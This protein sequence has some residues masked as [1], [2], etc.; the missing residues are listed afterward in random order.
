M[1]I[2]ISLVNRKRFEF[3]QNENFLMAPAYSITG[4]LSD[5]LRFGFCC[6][7]SYFNLEYSFPFVS[8][9]SIMASVGSKHPRFL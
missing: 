3:S 2:R 7:L 9:A 5:G 4:N 6:G 1:Q 8:R